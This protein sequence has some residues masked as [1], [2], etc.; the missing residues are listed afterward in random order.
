MAMPAS[1]V[2]TLVDRLRQPL[3]ASMFVRPG[4]LIVVA[5]TGAYCRSMA[6]NYNHMMKPPVISVANGAARTILRRETEADLL[7]LDVVEA[8]RIIK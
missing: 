8:P 5:A 6:S 2:I 1:N 3:S 7:A 4:D